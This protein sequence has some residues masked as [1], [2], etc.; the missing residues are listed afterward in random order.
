MVIMLSVV[1]APGGSWW[2]PFKHHHN[3]WL[4]ERLGP[5]RLSASG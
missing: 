3:P 5:D 1:A 2:I 4:R